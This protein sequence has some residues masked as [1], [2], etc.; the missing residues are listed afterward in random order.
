MIYVLGT[1][2][3]KY[4]RKLI[5]PIQLYKLKQMF[6]L[7]N[8]GFQLTLPLYASLMPSTSRQKEKLENL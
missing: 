4:K 2:G 6:N 5:L 1:Q 7:R 8:K 3:P